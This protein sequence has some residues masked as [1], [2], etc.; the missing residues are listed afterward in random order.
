MLLLD[1]LSILQNLHKMCTSSPRV[2]RKGL[3]LPLQLPQL[4]FVKKLL[5]PP[6]H[7]TDVRRDVETVESD[8]VVGVI[9]NKTFERMFML[10]NHLNG[11][12]ELLTHDGT[13]KYVKQ[14]GEQ[15]MKAGGARKA[16]QWNVRWYTKRHE[17]SSKAFVEADPKGNKQSTVV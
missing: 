15:K 13:H 17:D 7:G 12:F 9:A 1:L 2:R 14:S 11:L 5:E 4:S 3:H 10:I 6:R 16:I 8:C